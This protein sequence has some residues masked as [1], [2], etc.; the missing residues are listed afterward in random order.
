MGKARSVGESV[1]FDVQYP[2]SDLSGLLC[3]L[4][5][6]ILQSRDEM[7]HFWF[8]LLEVLTV[9]HHSRISILILCLGHAR[10]GLVNSRR[11]PSHSH[12][13]VDIFCSMAVQALLVHAAKEPMRTIEEEN[14]VAVNTFPSMHSPRL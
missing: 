14:S 4:H 8:P 2:Y 11:R 3:M 12:S 6:C 13:R 1:S 5:R 9:L 10:K 7:D